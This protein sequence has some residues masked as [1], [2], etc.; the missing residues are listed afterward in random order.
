MTAPTQPPEP[1]QD[2]PRPLTAGRALGI[3]CVFL[4]V[5][6][7]VAV[8]LV[9]A[10][11]SYFETRI[12]DPAA[13]DARVQSLTLLPSALLGTALG[14]LV[15]LR[16]TRRSFPGPLASG[17]LRPLGWAGVSRRMLGAN[18]AL[19]ASV[20][21]V[22]AYAIFRYLPPHPG[23]T[24]GPIAQAAS[25]P[26]LPRLMWAAFAVGI[27]PPAEEFL[28]RG[29]LLRG[30]A[31]SWGLATAVVVTTVAF[32]ALHVPEVH[33]Y[34][35][36]L[37]GISLLATL[38]ISIRLATRSLGPAVALHVGYNLALVLLAYVQSK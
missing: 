29:V 32:I 10:V 36:A 22:V 2:P 9:G 8:V 12:T 1:V 33:G 38:A 15:A 31:H 16:M 37:V 4:L 7:A 18:V 11:Q 30:L 28:F 23:Q 27:A 25:T 19:G 3:L 6:F 24:F 34:W 14:A 5:Q 13:L 26:G 21:L 35:P 20:A 17:T